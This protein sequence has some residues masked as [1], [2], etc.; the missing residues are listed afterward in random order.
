MDDGYN[1]Y[2]FFMLKTVVV[3]GRHQLQNSDELCLSYTQL[4]QHLQFYMLE[5][6]DRNIFDSNLIESV[7]KELLYKVERPEHPTNALYFESVR[8]FAQFQFLPQHH[9]HFLT[10][11]DDRR[12]NHE[13]FLCLTSINN[14]IIFVPR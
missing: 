10:D 13:G 2:K 9:D 5:D 11:A 8:S 3:A 12:I 4:V 7:E 14:N 6:F 1:E